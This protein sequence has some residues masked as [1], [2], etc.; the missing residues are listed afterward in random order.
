MAVTQKIIARKVGVSQKTVS[1][2]FK[3]SPH[4]A[5]KTRERI[6]QITE[7]YGYF[8]NLAARSIKTRCFKRI[9]MVMV[10]SNRLEDQSHPH[11]LTYL[12]TAADKLEKHG[13]SLVLEP[14]SIN[15]KTLNFIEE[16][17]F[18]KTLSVDGILGVAGTYVPPIVDDTISSM[19]QPVVWLNRQQVPEKIPHINFDEEANGRILAEYLREKGY[20]DIAWFG[21][22][23]QKDAVTHY[24]SQARYNGVKQVC[25][26]SG[27]KL[28]EVFAGIGENIMD[29]APAIFN[30][31]TRPQAIVCYNFDYADTSAYMLMQ[32]GIKH[33][34]DIEI[35]KFTSPWERAMTTSSSYTQLLLPE[36][37][38][39]RHGA[40]Y[41]LGILSGI[42]NDSLLQPLTG[43]LIVN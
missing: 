1:L 39:S 38:L 17:N 9:A 7:K 34:D 43:K 8:P 13:Y 22:E 24:S 11:L 40:E 23:F 16:P 33:P 15:M 6:K 27:I 21:P 18:F 41:I 29:A 2:Y 31:P 4:I 20:K 37:E 25:Q 5:P 14:F 30:F 42:K 32:M 36:L 35:V 12:S 3:G 26:E 19:G 10:Q 28:S